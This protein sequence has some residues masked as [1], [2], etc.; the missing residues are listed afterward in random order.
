MHSRGESQGGEMFVESSENEQGG[1]VP[2]DALYVLLLLAINK[3]V[4]KKT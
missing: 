4:A 1:T 2:G 3:L